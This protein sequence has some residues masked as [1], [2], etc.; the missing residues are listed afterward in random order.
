MISIVVFESG[1]F[2]TGTNEYTG[3]GPTMEIIIDAW[4]TRSHQ[5]RNVLEL[6]VSSVQ[7]NA[8]LADMYF[9]SFVIMAKKG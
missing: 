4:L 2:K 5:L 6:D 3:N 1:K 9:L 7:M 8:F